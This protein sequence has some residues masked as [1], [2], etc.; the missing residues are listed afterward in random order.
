MVFSA[1][2]SFAAAVVARVAAVKGDVRGSNNEPLQAG[3]SIRAG[4]VIS[5]AVDA[6]VLLRPTASVSVVGHMSTKL[7]FDGAELDSQGRGYANFTL[8]SGSVLVRIDESLE[9]ALAPSNISGKTVQPVFRPKDGTSGNSQP[10]GKVKVLVRTE[11]GVITATSGNWSVRSDEKRTIIAVAAGRTDVTIGGG[12]AGGQVEIPKGSVI[13][14]ERT[15]LSMSALSM[16][17][18]R[19]VDI[20]AGTMVVIQPDGTIDTSQK[21]SVALLTEASGYLQSNDAPTSTDL[22]T[23]SNGSNGPTMP[24]SNPDLSSPTVVLPV[25]SSDTP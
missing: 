15:A 7:R 12:S 11:L 16:V 24:A 8:L 20:Q 6:G 10:D 4:S 23:S 13:W 1:Q 5:T 3:S 25:V 17:L 19:I 2:P 9:D 18:T 22:I 14:L 21:P